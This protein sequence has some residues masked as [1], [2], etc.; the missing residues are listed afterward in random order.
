[1][2]GQK[3]IVGVFSYLDDTLKAIRKAKE[4]NLDYRVYSP[5]LR[6]EI[7]EATMPQ[8]S[9]VRRF[10]LVGGVTGLTCGFTL[11]IVCALD[12]PLRVSA[13]SIVSPPGFFVIGYECT[14]LFGALATLL[15]LLHFC[16]LP[17]ILRKVGFDP[18]F[19]NDKFGVVIGC[20]SN[21]VD[22]VKQKLIDSGAD[23]VQVRDGL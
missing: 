18:R 19:S 2:S 5:T 12:W 8:K 15:A 6:H 1:M 21:Q 4:A 7:E 22:E 23:E 9:P 11:A 14:I 3:A 17:N 16:R 13:K 20:E 10:T